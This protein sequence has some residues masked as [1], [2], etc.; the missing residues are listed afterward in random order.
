[1]MASS[2]H[3][4][5]GLVTY[6]KYRGGALTDSVQL[7]SFFPY[8]LAIT[9]EAFSQS[10]MQV[11]SRE[12]GLNREEWRL[13]FLLAGVPDITSLELGQRTTL[14]KVQVSRAAHRLEQKGLITRAI[15][16]N[17]RRLRLYAC[18]PSGRALFA[19]ILPKVEAQASDILHAI[20]HQ[21][22]AA[23]EHGL[24]ALMHAING[25]HRSD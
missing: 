2:P 22:R 6:S 18:T 24:G 20:P 8:K 23:L 14:D 25:M 9:A 10:L 7:D 16:P 3:Y 13:L 17:D 4:R 21:Q 12:Y 15:A 5:C 1:M 11:Y 19:E